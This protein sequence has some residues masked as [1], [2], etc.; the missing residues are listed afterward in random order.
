[1]ERLVCG[2]VVI[3]VAGQVSCFLNV[4]LIEELREEVRNQQ[5]T[6]KEN[7]N[8]LR[9]ILELLSKIQ[10]ETQNQ[11]EGSKVASDQQHETKWHAETNKTI[12]PARC[13]QREKI[14]KAL[15]TL[16]QE[17]QQQR[18][19]V[20]ND[21]IE[22]L[23]WRTEFQEIIAYIMKYQS[24]SNQQA[25]SKSKESSGGNDTEQVNRG[26]KEQHNVLLVFYKPSYRSCGKAL[27]KTSGKYNISPT[28]SSSP[29]SAYCEEEK[30]G[31]GWM[32]IQHRFNGSLSFN[33][34]WTDY[35]NGFGDVEGEHWLGLEKVY[36][37]TK[38]HTY[39]LLVEMKDFQNNYKYAKYSSFAIGSESESYRMTTLGTHSGTAGNSL[40]YHKGMKFSTPDKDNDVRDDANCA[41]ICAG[42]WWFTDCYNGFLNGLYR[43]VRA[44]GISIIAW[45]DF[46]NDLRG[47]SYSRMMIRPVN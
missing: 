14:L 45:Y 20:A 40:R 23:K 42:G 18:K 44:K 27:V 7:Q 22:F 24:L 26:N 1:M 46:N 38:E 11:I 10:R 13:A 12:V 37:L 25:E 47:L 39:E 29:F 15:I 6:F 30:F 4:S 21:R 41:Q 31:G 9:Q 8:H 17:A 19:D 35:R 28:A 16:Q 36:Q 5:K 33:R 3:L 32:V 34:N 2:I 43:K